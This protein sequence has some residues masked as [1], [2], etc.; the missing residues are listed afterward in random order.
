[1]Y[2]VG[3]EVKAKVPGSRK[4]NPGKIVKVNKDGTYNI[5]FED[6]E[7][8]KSIEEASIKGEEKAPAKKAKAPAKKETKPAAKAPAKRGRPAAKKESPAKKTTKPAAKAPAKKGG[9]K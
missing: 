5:T 6:G 8:G 4:Y 9:K 3:D 2:A 1:M 7:K